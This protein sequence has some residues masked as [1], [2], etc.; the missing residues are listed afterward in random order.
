VSFQLNYFREFA[1]S[2]G[3][4]HLTYVTAPIEPKRQALEQI[5]AA[6]GGTGP[7]LI[8]AQQWWLYWPIAYLARAQAGVSVSMTLS[9]AAP[10]ALD[11]GQLYLVE[12]AST[13]ELAS[14]MEW[15]AARGL[16]SSASVIRDASGRDLLDVVRVT[17]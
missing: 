9:D 4:S 17:R 11:E 2:G 5:V 14:A 3:R 13:P 16:R 7:V 8:V 12:F 15:I 10:H 1:T 6:R